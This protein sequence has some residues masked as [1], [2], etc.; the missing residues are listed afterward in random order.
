MMS[1]NPMSAV[2]NFFR[3]PCSS[4]L[5]WKHYFCRPPELWASRRVEGWSRSSMDR[6]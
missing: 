6:I 3:Q 1:D 5:S 4:R 2:I